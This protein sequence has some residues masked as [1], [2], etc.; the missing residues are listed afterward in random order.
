MDWNSFWNNGDWTELLLPGGREV[1]N[2]LGSLDLSGKQAAQTQ[3]QNQ[4]SLQQQAQGFNAASAQTQ[5]DW[6][7][8]M[9]NTE[10]QRR[11]ADIKAAGLNPW[12]A[13]QGGVGD[14]STPSGASASSS[15]GSA[16]M[17]N[18]KLAAAA[19]A[20]AVFLR[21]FLGKGK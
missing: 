9:S 13:L 18:N 2:L 16:S 6:E 20:F 4:L 3:Y 7:E 5:R 10:V 11:I 8:R 1:F 17:A 15:A 21:M 14:S 12:L 19:G